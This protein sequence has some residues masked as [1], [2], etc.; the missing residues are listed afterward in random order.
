[1]Y[2]LEL[3]ALG[4]RVTDFE[5]SHDDQLMVW[6]EDW[7]GIWYGKTIVEA[8]DVMEGLAAFIKLEL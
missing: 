8:V 1:V 6:F 2:L 4:Q 3:D 5:R 7:I